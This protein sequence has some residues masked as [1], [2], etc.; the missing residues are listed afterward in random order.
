[1]WSVKFQS[2][3]NGHRCKNLYFPEC[4]EGNSKE[5][6]KTMPTWLSGSL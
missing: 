4:K 1:M 5:R 2:K 3:R 6:T